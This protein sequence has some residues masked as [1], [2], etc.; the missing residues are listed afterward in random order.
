MDNFRRHKNKLIKMSVKEVV[1]EDTWFIAHNTDYSV[2]H[3]G[4]VLKG[5]EL[6]S[7]Q[8]VI[9]EFDNKDAWLERLRNFG[10]TPEPPTGP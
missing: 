8:P 1:T 10:I 3:Y 6:D 5:K 9:E 4:W 2:I 7:G